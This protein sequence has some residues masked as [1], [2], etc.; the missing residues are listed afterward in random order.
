MEIQE[1]TKKAYLPLLKKYLGEDKPDYIVEYEFY[2]MV[3]GIGTALYKTNLA[4]RD[5]IE[6]DD[7]ISEC[8]YIII[9]RLPTYK[10]ELK[11]FS[12][13]VYDQCNFRSKTKLTTDKNETEKFHGKVKSFD[14]LTA[15]RF[16]NEGSDCD[17][18]QSFTYREKQEYD[19]ACLKY[20][21]SLEN[22]LTKSSVINDYFNRLPKNYQNS[23]YLVK[24]EGYEVKEVARML[25]TNDTT[26]NN[27]IY[28]GKKMLRK[29]MEGPAQ[30][31]PS[32][33]YYYFVFQYFTMS[34]L[35]MVDALAYSLFPLFIIASISFVSALLSKSSKTFEYR[36]TKELSL[37]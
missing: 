12:S 4:G 9:K 24:V 18:T 35:Y 28:R 23:L 8:C 26:V 30:A 13:W 2:N 31:G 29:Y 10:P 20:S 1:G 7:F 36:L 17:E 15:D 11:K 21:Y 32:V 6:L 25:H 19:K 33:F 34:D 3:K 14:A 16:S 27:W 37:R 22:D 5:I